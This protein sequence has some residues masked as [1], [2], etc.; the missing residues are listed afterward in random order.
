[1]GLKCRPGSPLLTRASLRKTSAGRGSRWTRLGRW[2]LDRVR[3]FR[4]TATV[5]ST[6]LW[7]GAGSSTRSSGSSSWWLPVNLACQLSWWC[8]RRVDPSGSTIGE[9]LESHVSKPFKVQEK[10]E[11][12]HLKSV[13]GRRPHRRESFCLIHRHWA[14]LSGLCH[15]PELYTTV[16]HLLQWYI[17]TGSILLHSKTRLITIS[18]KPPTQGNWTGSGSKLLPDARAFQHVQVCVWEFA[19]E[20][21]NF[22]L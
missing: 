11:C 1:M 12:V 18:R 13:A 15:Q 6:M 16:N 4:R 21:K 22:Y 9:Y 2:S 7:R 10:R 17:T 20:T 3:I 14:T 8:C 5:G 19:K